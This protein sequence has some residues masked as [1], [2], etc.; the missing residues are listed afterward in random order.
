MAKNVDIM[1][2]IGSWSFTIGLLIAVVFGV[3]GSN[4]FDVGLILVLL[5]L[6]VGILNITGKET[7]PFLVV[8]IALITAGNAGL[9]GL[10]VVGAWL[11]AILG[12]V[13][14]FVAPAAVFVAVK[15]VYDLAKGA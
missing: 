6:I 9:E 3:L 7:V 12:N 14:V 8:A 1:T 4:L 2:K 15:A 11:G 13:Q 5:G 10:P